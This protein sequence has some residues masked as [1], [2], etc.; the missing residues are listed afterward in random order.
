LPRGAG[1]NICGRPSMLPRIVLRLVCSGG[2][3]GRPARIIRKSYVSQ[4]EHLCVIYV[5]AF[6]AIAAIKNFIFYSSRPTFLT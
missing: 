2:V 1:A 4:R 5:Y 6:Y 3:S